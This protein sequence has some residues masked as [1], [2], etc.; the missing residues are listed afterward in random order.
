M[1]CITSAHPVRFLL[2]LYLKVSY[3]FSH[4]GSYELQSTPTDFTPNLNK[5]ICEIDNKPGTTQISAIS[6]AQK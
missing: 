2:I 4:F 1:G 6:K 5:H 3:L